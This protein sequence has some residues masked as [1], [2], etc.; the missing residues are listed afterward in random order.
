[1]DLPEDSQHT[2]MITSWGVSQQGDVYKENQDAFLNWPDRKFWS[3]AD[4]VGGTQH[5]AKA[6]KFIIR[7][8]LSLKEPESFDSFVSATKERILESNNILY[9]RTMVDGSA[10][11]TVVTLLIHGGQAACLWAGDSRCYLLRNEILYQCTHDHTLRQ[12]KIDRRELT[13]SEAYHMVKGNVIT[14]AVGAR[15]D[16]QLD[17]VR[18]ALQAEDRFLLCSDGLSNLLSPSALRQYMLRGSP[19]TSCEALSTSL[20]DR[21]VDDNVTFIVI[22]LSRV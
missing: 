6:S 18:F 21:R 1:M 12:H 16:L 3:V 4:G 9:S 5:G 14:N 20:E 19:Q 22:F 10:V 13:V 8:F 17:E 15:A 2:V 7:S 11:S